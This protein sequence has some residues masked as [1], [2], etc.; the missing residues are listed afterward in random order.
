MKSER[1][2]LLDMIR[3]INLISMIA[4]H[5]CWDLQYM[6]NVDMPW[7]RG[8]PGD[9]WQRFIC[10]TFI[11]LSG[12]CSFL[13]ASIKKKVKRGIIVMVCGEIVSLVTFFAMP[14]NPIHF[15][16][17]TFMG[18]AMIVFAVLDPFI[19]ESEPIGNIIILICCYLFTRK[20][21]AGRLIVMSSPVLLP[22]ELYRNMFTA[23]LGFPPVHFV[24]SDYFPVIPWIFIYALGYNV[25]KLF[26][27]YD[28][29]KYLTKPANGPFNIIGKNSLIIY[30][31]HQPVIYGVLLL[32]MR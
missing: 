12:F 26:K 10:M 6:F 16:I 29:M 24:S 17:L 13:G 28:L 15:G 8:L 31:L 21:S 2:G 1:Y 25:G 3:G 4:F 19:K 9:L 23:F 5:A 27:K 22:R 30:M 11:G 7:Y 32:I 14:D 20:V 18:F